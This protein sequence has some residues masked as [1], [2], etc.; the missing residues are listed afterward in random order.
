MALGHVLAARRLTTDPPISIDVRAP[1][2][3][4][5]FPRVV[6]ENYLS[7]KDA[8]RLFEFALT[9]KARFKRS[10][11]EGGD[12]KARGYRH[13]RDGWRKKRALQTRERA[14]PPRDQWPHARQ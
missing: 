4:V 11:V 13:A 8:A 3:N 1:D 14:A 5:V 9:N 7:K 2:P 6:E 10:K 12:R